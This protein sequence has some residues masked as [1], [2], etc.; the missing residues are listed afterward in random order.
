MDKGKVKLVTKMGRNKKIIVEI[1]I[2]PLIII[3]GIAAAYKLAEDNSDREKPD[4]TAAGSNFGTIETEIHEKTG[5]TET[6]E[7][8]ETME[9]IETTGIIEPTDANSNIADT[10]FTRTYNILNINDSND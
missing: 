6:T 7:I 4:S 8:I 3:I 2:V 5:I 9:I 10:I 1:L